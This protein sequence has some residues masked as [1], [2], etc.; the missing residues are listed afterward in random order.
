MINKVR[1]Y[2]FENHMLEK[3]DHIVLGVSGG[4]D[5]VAL[6]MV[7]CSLQKEWKLKLNVIHVHHGIRPE[8]DEDV[9][10]VE[11]L[12]RSLEVPCHVFYEDVPALAAQQRISEEEMG[13]ACRYMHFMEVARETESVKIAV[14]HHMDDQAETVLF[15]LIRGT[16]LAGMR[17]MLPV[18]RMEQAEGLIL[19]RPLLSCRKEELTAYLTAQQITWR[20]D[21][22]NRENR[23]ARNRIRN[24]VIPQFTA[25]NEQAVVHIADFAVQ[26]AAYEKF[27]FVQVKRYVEEHVRME[28]GSCIYIDRNQLLKEEAVFI[29]G[30][31]YELLCRISGRKKDITA[32][33]VQAVYDLLMKQS[34]RAV[35]LPYGMEAKVSYENLIIGK[36]SVEKEQEN[37]IYAMWNWAEMIGRERRIRVG[38]GV[39]SA[40]VTDFAKVD[41]NKREIFLNNIRNSKNNYT[42]YFGCD[43]IKNT[44]CIRKPKPGD[45]LIIDQAGTHKR[46]SR[47]FIDAKI[48]KEDRTDWPLVAE[49]DSVLWVIGRRRAEVFPVCM[50]TQYILELRYEGVSD[51][52]SY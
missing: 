7:L 47:Y 35:S 28:E 38:K 9:A 43:T 18:S 37:E 23:Y 3:G 6:L 4:A 31:L 2:I 20:E 27:F 44:L 25:V 41:P 8:A 40:K 14:A 36:C 34:G 21:V 39:L 24:L 12:C 49:E 10:F 15:H 52:L 11:Q 51:E 5:S 45:Y 13:R 33:L 32:V 19:I 1:K 29:Q 16:D 48:P 42:K 46:L 26:A 17:G 30:I 22:T 50:D